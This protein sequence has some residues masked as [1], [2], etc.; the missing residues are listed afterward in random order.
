VWTRAEVAALVDPA[1]LDLVCRYWDISDEGNFEGKNIPHV[2]LSLEQVAKMFGREPAAAAAAIERARKR[3]LEVRA[4][5]VPPYAMARSSP[6][7]TA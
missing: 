7:G 1:D 6:A 2:T 3:L 5:R 4:K